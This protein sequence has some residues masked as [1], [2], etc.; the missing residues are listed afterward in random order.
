MRV[1]V[2]GTPREL[3]AG[4]TVAD[5]ARLAGVAPGERGVAVAIDG[6]VVPGDRWPDTELGEGSR[7]E[8]VRAAAGG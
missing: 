6:E 4:A 3:P 5:A 1:Q 8:I 7:V 2:N